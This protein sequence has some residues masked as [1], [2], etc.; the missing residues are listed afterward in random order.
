MQMMTFQIETENWLGITHDVMESFLSF[1]LDIVKMEVKP[2]FIYLKTN[3]LP[4][5]LQDQLCRHITHTS[6]V[7]K[8]HVIPFL[9]SELHANELKTTLATISNGVI[10]V[11]SNLLV[12]TMNLAAETLLQ[13]DEKTYKG[14]ELPTLWGITKEDCER[15]MK[16]ETSS[17][18]IYMEGNRVIRVV[19]D[20]YPICMSENDSQGWVVVFRDLQQ[21]NEWIQSVQRS[22]MT[23]FEEIIHESKGMKNCIQT[24][25]C[26]AKGD[27]T[28]FLSGE[29]GT[30]KELFARA[31]HYESL[32]ANG[33]FIPINCAAIPE[34]LLESELF[35]YEAGSFTGASKEGKEGLFE[36]ARNGTLFLDE[37]GEIPLHLQSKLLRVL[38]EKS[39]RRIGSNKVIPLQFRLITATN[40]KLGEW[41]KQGKFRED[42]YYR[43]HVIPIEIPPLRE[44]ECEILLLANHFLKKTCEWVRRPVLRLS[45]YARQQLYLHD[46]PGN[47]RE[48]QNVMER[49]VY[50]CPDHETEIH[51]VSISPG[52]NGLD[53]SEMLE[54]VGLKPH[55][56]LTER[57]IIKRTLEQHSS[58][59]QAARQLRMSHTAL[60]KKIK[61]YDL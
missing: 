55:L 48:L 20:F 28:I 15:L 19:A 52:R 57:R 60:L 38:E 7:R 44:R 26:V 25:R 34:Q 32:R 12:N 30:G 29:S 39:I 1:Q 18:T 5:A 41:V 47:V 37:V 58:I 49:S 53:R 45:E 31:I 42:L 22:E 11:D 36:T 9:P 2:H 43:L 14:M 16:K 56:E 61:K 46:W 51:R 3:S 13:T 40:R 4:S 35:G 50:L 33:P 23:H 10:L 54:M 24:A 59:R 17:L 8:V 27:V 21:A 6:G